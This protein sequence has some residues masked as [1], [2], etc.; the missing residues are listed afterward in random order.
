[1][2]PKLHCFC[3]RPDCKYS[4]WSRTWDIPRCCPKCKSYRWNQVQIEEETVVQPESI[5]EK[6]LL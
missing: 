6:A 5:P 4:W 2:E 3:R 1:M